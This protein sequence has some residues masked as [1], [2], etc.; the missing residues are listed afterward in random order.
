MRDAVNFCNILLDDTIRQPLFRLH[1]NKRPWRVGLFDGDMKDDR[2]EIET[3]D[4]ILS[5]AD[6]IRATALK[7]NA[8]K[9]CKEGE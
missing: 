9:K 1:F 7:Y 3:L 6:R 2:V 4:D 5:L 8:V